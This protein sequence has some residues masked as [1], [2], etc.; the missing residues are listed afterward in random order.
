MPQ[1]AGHCPKCGLLFKTE[2]SFT[3]PAQIRVMCIGCEDTMIVEITTEDLAKHF[4]DQT[5]HPTPREPW[6]WT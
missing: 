6:T 2:R 5:T 3:V 1:V 4:A